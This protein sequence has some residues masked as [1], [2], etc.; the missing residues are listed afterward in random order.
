MKDAIKQLQ[1]TL[2][3]LMTIEQYCELTARCM[4]SAFN[5]MRNNPGLA[6]KIGGSTRFLRDRVLADIVRN[7]WIPE[8]ER[9]SADTTLKKSTRSRKGHDKQTAAPRRERDPEMRA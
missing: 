9:D 2:P 5:D 6:V 1:A 4:G 7:K 3:P 8:K